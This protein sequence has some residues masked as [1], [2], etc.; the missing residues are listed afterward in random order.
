MKDYL[1]TKSGDESSFECDGKFLLSEKFINLVRSYVDIVEVD[2]SSKDGSVELVLV[3]TKEVLFE[4]L[5]EFLK[6]F[7]L[8]HF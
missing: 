8:D 4:I 3:E 7:G 6:Y 2:T 1:D 5:L